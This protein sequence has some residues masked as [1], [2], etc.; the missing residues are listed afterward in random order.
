MIKKCEK[1]FTAPVGGAISEPVPKR[2]NNCSDPDKIEWF[3]HTRLNEE[4]NYRLAE[5]LSFLLELQKYEQFYLSRCF[6]FG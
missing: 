1:I 5:I 6:V 3:W 2:R 4:V